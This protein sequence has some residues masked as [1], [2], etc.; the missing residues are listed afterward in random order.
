MY[1]S[2][3]AFIASH[4]QI[5]GNLPIEILPS[6]IIRAASNNEIDVIREYINKALPDTL[7]GWVQYEKLLKEEKIENTIQYSFKELP[8][9]KWK[10]WILAF[11][12]TDNALVVHDLEKI[13]QMLPVM[14]DYGFIIYYSEENQ[15]GEITACQLMPLHVI[16]R[17]SNPV[18]IHSNA[19]KINK[20]Q[21]KVI[22]SL[23]NKYL[24]LTSDFEF[25]SH[26]LQNF[27][28]LRRVPE[29]SD[30]I[31]LGLFSILETLIT[32]KP[33]SAETLDSINH[34]MKNKMILIGKKY[35]R[36][37]SVL[38]YF[39]SSSEDKIWKELHEY[40]SCI[41]HGNK[42]SNNNNAILKNRDAVI[43]F[44]RDNVKELLKYALSDPE[45]ISDLRK[46]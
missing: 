44:L 19:E 3:F 23:Y 26:A 30:L 4:L 27:Y 17:Y 8:R 22:G 13:C 35:L 36:K 12:K 18:R 46:C 16:E 32:H 2:G 41:A 29:S 25:I 38:Q 37:I 33:R 5:D 40:R 11:E 34:Q 1:K 28:D 24:K 6:H 45:F 39:T 21:I 7:F 31:I 20:K 14:F 10:Y 42:V 9:K 43:S 15:K